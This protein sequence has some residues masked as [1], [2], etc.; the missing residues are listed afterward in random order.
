MNVLPG[1][2]ISEQIFPL[3]RKLGSHTTRLRT[4]WGFPPLS[5]TKPGAAIQI[6]QT[7][8]SSYSLACFIIRPLVEPY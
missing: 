4:F 3:A 7:N 8:A 2:Y 5:R 6:T 1:T